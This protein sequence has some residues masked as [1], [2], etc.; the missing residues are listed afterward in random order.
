MDYLQL[1]EDLFAAIPRQ[2]PGSPAVLN[3]ALA[4]CDLD[5]EQA[6]QVADIGCGTGTSTLALARAL[7]ADITAV[8]F[9]PRFLARLEL[10]AQEA[11][12]DKRIQTVC[13]SMDALP[14]VDNSLDLIFSEGA[15]YN[16][17]FASGVNSWRRF[18]KPGGLLVVSEIT[19]CHAN[20]PATLREYWEQAYPEVGTAS[21]KIQVLE[22]AGYSPI[23]HF[24]LPQA[25]W[26]EHYYA[27]LAEQ[28]APFLARH[29]DNDDAHSIVA[30]NQ[31]EIAMY[32]EHSADFTYGMYI[33]RKL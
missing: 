5:P 33:A 4:L 21:S 25:A 26:T 13:G 6:L 10:Q 18:L 8:D 24:L 32:N 12:L 14:F 28:F 9:L 1:L 7:N 29:P 22:N 20:P 15:I 16:I 31:A 3:R 19:W 11:G 27:P 30:D 2:G 23:A 17:G